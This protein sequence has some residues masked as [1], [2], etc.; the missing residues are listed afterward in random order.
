MSDH[1]NFNQLHNK[2]L[3]QELINIGYKILLDNDLNGLHFILNK[4]SIVS[5]IKSKINLIGENN[6]TN[7]ILLIIYKFKFL[8]ALEQ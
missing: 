1:P 5:F 3:L 4:S 6:K 7:D 2:V 8:T